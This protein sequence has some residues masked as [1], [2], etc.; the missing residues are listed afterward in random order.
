MIARLVPAAVFK[1]VVPVL[2]RELGSIPRRSRHLKKSVSA[3][4]LAF[5]DDKLK[6]YEQIPVQFNVFD[7]KYFI[8]VKTTNMS[9]SI[10]SYVQWSL[11]WTPTG[12]LHFTFNIPVVSSVNIVMRFP[13]INFSKF[14]FS[15]I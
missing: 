8:I 2:N 9:V 10:Y 3:N 6:Y 13:C 4:I 5:T 15:K 1:T 14:W 12:F 7:T 11:Q